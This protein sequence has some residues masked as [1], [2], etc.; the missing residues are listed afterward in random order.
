MKKSASIL[1]CLVLL[2]LGGAAIVS[3]TM[4]HRYVAFHRDEGTPIVF[5][6][7][8]CEFVTL[9]SSV[10]KGHGI[11]KKYTIIRFKDTTKNR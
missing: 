6:Q 11:E 8:K 1:L 4:T 9:A 7:F 5:D 2:L 3:Y 10:E